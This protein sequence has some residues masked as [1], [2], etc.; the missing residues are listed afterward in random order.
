MKWLMI[1]LL[2]LV[3]SVTVALVALPDP[4]YVLIGYGK[5]SVEMTLLVFLVV[6][7]FA[8]LALRFVAGLWRVPGRVQQWGGRRQGRR[9]R[10][11]YDEAVIELTE[12]RLE[13]AERRLGRLT[14]FRETPLGV[15]L[16]AARAAS[17]LGADDRRDFYLKLALQRHPEGELAISLVQAELQLARTQLDQAQTTLT[18]LQALSPHNSEVMRLLMQLYLRQNDWQKL[19]DLLPELKRSHT[20]DKD[21]WQQLAVQVYRQHVLEFAAARDV[22]GL[23]AGWKQLPPPVQQDAGLLA[24]YIEQLVH[25]GSSEQAE[26]LLRERLRHEWNQRLVYLYGDLSEADAS[27]QQVCAEKWLEAHPEDPVLLLTLGKISLRNQ[28]WGKARSYLESSIGKQ[29]TPEAYRLLGSLLERLDEPDQA[30]ECYGKGL[31]LLGQGVSEA[32]L[33]AVDN[34]TE[35]AGQQPLTGVSA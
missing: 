4:G 13:R 34:A 12:G 22:N 1:G 11:L 27:S 3:A 17:H 16:S 26:S 29:A 28:L 20:V 23:Q 32:A 30:A 24:V 25:L 9:L 33:P 7:A 35:R 2:A 5:H 8:Y 31:E 21:Q 19:R 14:H 15:Y 6:L 10:K 18:R